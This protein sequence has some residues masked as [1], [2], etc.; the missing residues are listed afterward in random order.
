MSSL[1]PRNTLLTYLQDFRLRGEAI[2][3]VGRQSLRTDRWSYRRVAETASSVA[4]KLKRIGLQKG[5]RVLLWSENS[6]AWVVVFF[7]CMTEGIV[8]VPLDIHA[9]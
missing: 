5:D 1:T 3:Y 7:G 6:P 9:P 2:A 4:A 8:I